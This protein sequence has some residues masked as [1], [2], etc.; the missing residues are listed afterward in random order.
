MSGGPELYRVRYEPN[1]LI[2]LDD[3]TVLAAS[4]FFPDEAGRFPALLSCYPYL[5]DE[6]FGAFVEPANRFFAARG[7]V[8]I[9][10]DLRGTGGSSGRAYA[11]FAHSGER[12]DCAAAVEWIAQQ[13]WCDG[14][15]GMW[16]IS[17]GG[18]TSL[19]TAA[20]QPPH[21]RAIAPVFGCLDQYSDWFAPG[22]CQ[23][24]LGANSWATAQLAHQLSPPM[25]QDPDGR[26]YQLWEERLRDPREPWLLAWHDHLAYDSYWHEKTTDPARYSRSHVS[27]R[28]VARHVL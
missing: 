27:D 19:S 28:G 12:A 2:P 3:G 17:Y 22:G 7:Y 23:K 24:F 16:G 6:L 9:F 14:N 1:I 18:I 8:A 25:H 15:V 21:L 26:W 20:A 10:A 5:K 13:T 4:A 11:S